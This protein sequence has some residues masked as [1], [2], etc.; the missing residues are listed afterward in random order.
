[1]HHSAR[2]A[3]EEKN[4][5]AHVMR[6]Y[7]Q[8]RSVATKSPL[9]PPAVSNF[10][11]HMIRFPLL[12]RR[13]RKRPSAKF[14]RTTSATTQKAKRVIQ[15]RC[16]QDLQEAVLAKS[17]EDGV[18]GSL[19]SPIDTSRTDTSALLEYYHTSF[20]DNSLAVNPEGQWLSVAISDPAMLHATLCLVALHKLQ[21]HGGGDATSYFWHRGEA[22]RLVSKN[23]TEP[24]QAASDANIAAV[25]ILSA[26][27]NSV[28]FFNFQSTF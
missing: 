19:P 2:N 6:H 7:L 4:I 17:L 25:A 11:D 23:L 27:D 20:W 3:M 15:P 8:H 1:M 28:S 12:S 10:S 16:I 26:S 22:I 18:F 21:T 24:G 14:K 5:R 13:G 9:I